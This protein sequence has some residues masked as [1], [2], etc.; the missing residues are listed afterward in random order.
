MSMSTQLARG[1]LAVPLLLGFM[2]LGLVAAR[3]APDPLQMA[4]ARLL[5]ELCEVAPAPG[6]TLVLAQ[7]PAD[8]GQLVLRWQRP[9]DG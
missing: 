4:Q 7:A 5:A 2:A 3:A 6:H 8:L 1:T 9:C